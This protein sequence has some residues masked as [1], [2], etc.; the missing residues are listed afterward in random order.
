MFL[1]G[2]QNRAARLF[3]AL[4]KCIANDTGHLSKPEFIHM[5]SF[6][7]KIIFSGKPELSL[8]QLKHINQKQTFYCD[9]LDRLD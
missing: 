8:V 2:I 4:T 1:L 3:T 5:L 9:R 6:T 7:K